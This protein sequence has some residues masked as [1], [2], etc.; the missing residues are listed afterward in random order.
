MIVVF[1]FFHSFHTFCVEAK[2]HHN[3]DAL[4]WQ[5][6]NSDVTKISLNTRYAAAALFALARCA[7]GRHSEVCTCNANVCVC[8][9]CKLEGQLPS[10]L[11]RKYQPSTDAR[12]SAM[13]TM[14]PFV[15][16]PLLCHARLHGSLHS[17]EILRFFHVFLLELSRSA[18]DGISIFEI[19]I[20]WLNFCLILSYYYD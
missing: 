3:V 5:C 19:L 6:Q 12:H 8:S 1:S 17:S 2:A 10:F 14:Y 4:S 15:I 20:L 13:Q 16:M 9:V 11:G 7:E 18:L